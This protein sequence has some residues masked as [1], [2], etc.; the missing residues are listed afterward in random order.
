MISRLVATAEAD[1]AI[2]AVGPK[3]LDAM[4]PGRIWYLGGVWRGWFA[5]GVGEGEPDG[6]R[7]HRV[8]PVDFV[9]GCG[10]LLRCA[11]LGKVGL[12]DERFFMYYEDADLCLRL[13]RAGYRI[14]ADGRARMWHRVAQST[15]HDVPLRRFLRERSR[16][17]FQLRAAGPWRQAPMAALLLLAW[18]R[19]AARDAR[20][21]RLSAAW[22]AARG[23]WAGWRDTRSQA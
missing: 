16:T 6:P 13:A 11:A 17:A 12:F 2:G 9:S 22:A 18:A 10:M 1:P 8:W 21:G 7:W 5:A 23:L 4:A 20:A 3:V 15:A 14:V 19:Q